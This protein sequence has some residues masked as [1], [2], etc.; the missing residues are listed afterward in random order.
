MPALA[1]WW[2]ATW[3]EARR[4]WSRPIQAVI[5]RLTSMG[6]WVRFVG[7]PTVGGSLG[8]G[9][10]PA[11][12]GGRV[13]QARV[14]PY[15]GA[16]GELADLAPEPPRDLRSLSPGGVPP[17]TGKRACP[18]SVDRASAARERDDGRGERLD[19]TLPAR[20]TLSL[21]VQEGSQGPAVA[22]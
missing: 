2:T 15:E 9:G 21:L 11:D 3:V 20:R 1:S 8:A 5:L 16:D 19:P 22:D 13:L 6:S 18:K 4:S 10:G 17:G 12:E 14:P 7:I